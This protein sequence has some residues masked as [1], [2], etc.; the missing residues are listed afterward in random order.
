M[1]IW[2]GPNP[3][4]RTNLCAK[5]T[6]ILGYLAQ[7]AKFGD[8]PVD[9]IVC[10]RSMVLPLVKERPCNELSDHIDD[11]FAT[12]PGVLIHEYMHWAFLVRKAWEDK[13]PNRK[14][15]EDFKG[16]VPK[17]GYGQY[18][19]LE[20][21]DKAVPTNNADNFRW[22]ATEAYYHRICRPSLEQYGPGR[23]GEPSCALDDGVDLPEQCYPD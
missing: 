2:F 3:A 8:G 6:M 9:L 10:P 7:D 19:V 21:R 17:N 16:P 4:K 1:T 20:V 22:F 12:L 5:G 11:T 14:W 18:Q 13:D 23:K 15:I